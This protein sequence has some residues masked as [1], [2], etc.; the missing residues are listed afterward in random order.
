M[1]SP[2]ISECALSQRKEALGQKSHARLCQWGDSPRCALHLTDLALNLVIEAQV[3]AR[4]R[5]KVGEPPRGGL[6]ACDFCPNA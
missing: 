2:P 6:L 3:C 1:S 4:P 5:S